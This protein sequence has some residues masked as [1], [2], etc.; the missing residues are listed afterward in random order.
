VISEFLSSLISTWHPK[1]CLKSSASSASAAPRNRL[2]LIC[3]STTLGMGRDICRTPLSTGAVP[4][5][6][7]SRFRKFQAREMAATCPPGPLVLRLVSARMAARPGGLWLSKEAATRCRGRRAHRR[8]WNR[9]YRRGR[10]APFV[11]YIHPKL[12]AVD[13]SR[14]QVSG[15]HVRGGNRRYL[16][17][18]MAPK[19]GL[20]RANPPGSL[21]LLKQRPHGRLL[22]M[23]QPSRSAALPKHHHRLSL[24][25][26][27]PS[28]ISSVLALI[29]LHHVR[30]HPA[31]ATVEA[32]LPLMEQLEHQ[33]STAHPV[34]LRTALISS[35]YR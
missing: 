28:R 17:S 11:W 1:A 24:A 35:H 13:K 29:A 5:Q 10:H 6:P 9:S 18:G 12:G 16:W 25:I 19:A 20:Q 23:L 32:C 22:H 3:A 7:R 14:A 26:Q 30:G 31:K 33:G 15:C 34:S 4:P 21:V 2:F 8:P 27:L